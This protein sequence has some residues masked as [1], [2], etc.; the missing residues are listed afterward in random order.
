MEIGWQGTRQVD[1]Y[2]ILTINSIAGTN[3]TSGRPRAIVAPAC[4]FLPVRAVASH[5]TGITANAADDV[6]RVVLFLWTVV[7]SVTY[8]AAVLACLVLI[9]PEGTV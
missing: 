5:V 4:A 2:L 6:S 7:L 1:S 3:A 8:L 9:V